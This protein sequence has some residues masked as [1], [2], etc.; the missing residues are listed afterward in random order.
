MVHGKKRDYRSSATST[1]HKSVMDASRNVLITRQNIDLN[2]SDEDI[3]FAE[4]LELENARTKSTIRA[5]CIFLKTILESMTVSLILFAVFVLGET[6]TIVLQIFG[7][8]EVASMIA[9]TLSTIALLVYG[10][11]IVVSTVALG[12]CSYFRH[13]KCWLECCI[14]LVDIFALWFSTLSN[15][16]DPILS[17]SRH[18][19]IV[20]FCTFGCVVLLHAIRIFHI[21]YVTLKPAILTKADKINNPSV[22]KKSYG[23]ICSVRGILINRKYSSMRFAAKDLL[24]PILG[25]ELSNLFSMEFYGTREKDTQDDEE[26]LIHEMI[27][28]KRGNSGIRSSILYGDEK[29]FLCA[30]RPDWNSIFLKAIASAHCTNPEGETVGIFFCGSPAIAKDLQAEAKKVTAQHQF[31]MKHLHGKACKCKLIVHSESF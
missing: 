5:D 11:T 2:G 16:E 22:A 29:K 7:C 6:F 30:G 20:Y 4:S 13:F 21:F 10:T 28:S 25:G 24:P 8:V 1:T 18:D 31:A 3:S 12:C 19:T 17:A 14:V 26:S 23:S 15:L 27:H 9:Y